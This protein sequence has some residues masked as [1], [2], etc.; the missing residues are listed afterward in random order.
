MN[1]EM[2]LRDRSYGREEP[3]SQ[4]RARVSITTNYTKTNREVC[5]N[6]WKALLID[7]IG[8]KKIPSDYTSFYHRAGIYRGNLEV[9]LP[10]YTSRL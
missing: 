10:R 5:C 3:G 8:R 6:V 1:K 7:D 4:V 9:R 2:I